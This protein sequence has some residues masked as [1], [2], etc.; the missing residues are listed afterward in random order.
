MNRIAWLQDG[1]TQRNV[2]VVIGVSLSAVG[3]H[4]QRNQATYS[5]LSASFRMTLKH[6][7]QRLSYFSFQPVFHDWCN[8]GCGMYYPV[9]G[10]MHIKEPLLLI[11]KS[12]LCCASRFPLL[13]SELSF[14]ICPMPY[15]RK[16]NVLSASLNKTFLS[17]FL[18]STNRE[19][20]CISRI[21]LCQCLLN[22]HSMTICRH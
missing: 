2:A 11:R 1:N 17:F 8:K 16:Y 7:K 3:Q 22:A 6:Y 4:W 18:L 19:D 9:G 10:M 15:N 5:T 20:F 14:T 12:S 13:L 21:A